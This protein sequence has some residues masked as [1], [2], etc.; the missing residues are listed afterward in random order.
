[1]RQV[2]QIVI[3]PTVAMPAAIFARIHIDTMF[4]PVSGGFKLIVQARCALTAYVEWRMLRRETEKTL[5]DFIYQDILC[6][7]GGVM[8]IIT[9]NGAAFVKAMRRIEQQ[10]GVH[11]IRISGYNSRAN[12][13]VERPHFDVRQALFKAADGDQTKWSQVAHSVFWSERV[14]IRRRMGC[15]PYFAVTGCHPILPFDISE[16]TYLMPAPQGLISTTELIARRAIA[17]QRRTEDVARLQSTVY[18][19]RIRAAQKFERD[20]QHTMRDFDFASGALVLVRHTQI[21]KSLNRKMRARYTGPVV[22]VS[23]NRGGAYV[24]CELDGTVFHRPVGAFRLLPYFARQHIA[25]PPNFADI[26]ERRLEE[27]VSSEDDG[28]EDED[29]PE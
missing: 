15:S 16:A 2:R 26:S 22:V 8:E 23:R 19:A 29:M 5:A 1:M 21:E 9:D 11:H 6:R 24:V 13:L 7:W 12:G 14:T 20:H 10:H 17:L 4:M 3:P 25:L 18:S 27:L 28:A